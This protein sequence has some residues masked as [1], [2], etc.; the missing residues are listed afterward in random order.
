MIIGLFSFLALAS[1]FGGALFVIFS[2][3]G[4]QD[5]LGMALVAG[6]FLVG[7]GLFLVAGA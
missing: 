5:T 3:T 1:M 6:G 2:K 7:F 4:E